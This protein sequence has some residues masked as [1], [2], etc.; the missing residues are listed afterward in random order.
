LPNGP[1]IR[2][3]AASGRYQQTTEA[4]SVE[5]SLDP[6]PTYDP[7]TIAAPAEVSPNVISETIVFSS[8]TVPHFIQKPFP[9]AASYS[10]TVP[11]QSVQIAY[12]HSLNLSMPKAEEVTRHLGIDNQPDCR[13]ISKRSVGLYP[14][15]LDLDVQGKSGFETKGQ[16][17]QPVGALN[18]FD[19]WIGYCQR[20]QL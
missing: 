2:A 5:H 20:K 8:I 13:K 10:I 12:S 14:S 19:H 3:C 6:C 9:A 15:L 7:C 16:S 4:K 11:P 18:P 17:G 1:L